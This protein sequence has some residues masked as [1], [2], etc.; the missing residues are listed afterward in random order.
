MAHFEEGRGKGAAR[1]CVS[2][3]LFFPRPYGAGL[4]CAAPRRRSRDAE[5]A[6]TELIVVAEVALLF[7]G[8]G[9]CT[10]RNKG[11]GRR[12]AVRGRV[13]GAGARPSYIRT[14]RRYGKQLRFEWAHSVAA[15]EGVGVWATGVILRAAVWRT[16]VLLKGED[17]ELGRDLAEHLNI[18]CWL[19][20]AQAEAYAT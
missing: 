14:S 5:S 11:A 17:K 18:C 15:C 8:E 1:G 9:K 16:P 6:P 13:K 19:V 4:N 7:G 12:P 3:R 2:A 10:E 20:G